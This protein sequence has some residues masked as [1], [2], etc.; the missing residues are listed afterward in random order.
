MVFDITNKDSF[1]NLN[2]WKKEFIE[3]TNCRDPANF[4][5]LLVG[6]KGDCQLERNVSKST[7]ESWAEEN[8]CI[9][10]IESSAKEYSNVNEAFE[11]VAKHILKKIK[12]DGN[13]YV[14]YNLMSFVNSHVVC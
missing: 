4:P 12:F 5:F 14:L 13:L 1:D 11:E 7:A 3:Q 8:N 10:Y 6:N 2:D 9:A